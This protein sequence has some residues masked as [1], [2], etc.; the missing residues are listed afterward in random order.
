MTFWQHDETGRI[1]KCD[2]NPGV[3]WLPVMIESV[4]LPPWHGNTVLKQEERI[5]ELEAQVVELRTALSL[6]LPDAEEQD[7]GGADISER[8]GHARA[9]LMKTEPPNPYAYPIHEDQA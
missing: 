7:H 9:V 1:T 3:R 5:T 4:N 6:I 2:H 8:L